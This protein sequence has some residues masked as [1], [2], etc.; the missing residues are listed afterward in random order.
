MVNMIGNDRFYRAFKVL[1]TGEGDS[2]K[3]VVIA[4]QILQPINKIELPD[5]LWQRLQKILKDA[6]KSDSMTN[7]NGDV[8]RDAFT[9]T[10]HGKRNSTYSKI[11]EDIYRLY[12]DEL[13]H[14]LDK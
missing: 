11:A 12:V 2:R 4:C 5:D 14:R 6:Q 7:S 13:I 9:C 10:A 1:V 3:R 8:I